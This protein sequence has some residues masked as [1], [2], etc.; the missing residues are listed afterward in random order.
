[1]HTRGISER[2]AVIA[3]LLLAPFFSQAAEALLTVRGKVKTPLKLTLGE[4][5]A[6]PIAK[7]TAKD[8]DGTSATYEGVA[9]HDILRRAG[10]PQGESLHK[11]ALQL[12]VLAKAADGYKV[13]FTL[14]ELDPSF[15]ERQVLLAYTRNGKELDAK[16]GPF[17]V[18]IPDE[19]KH[20]RW[21]RQV[22]ELEVVRV[23]GADSGPKPPG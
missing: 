20:G 18:V 11:D 4:L 9:L 3:L 6:L 17:R 7:V 10:V 8:P 13:V 1:M 5:K 12:C 2:C 22:T 19:K 15:T 14:A 16:T 21:I 23:G